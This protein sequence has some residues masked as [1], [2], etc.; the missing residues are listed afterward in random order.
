MSF[1]PALYQRTY[2]MP[3]A[4]RFSAR[5][6]DMWD[7]VEESMMGKVSRMWGGVCRKLMWWRPWFAQIIMIPGRVKG[8]ASRGDGV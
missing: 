1:D 8:V 5:K 4:V 7:N 3:S 6:V 2:Y